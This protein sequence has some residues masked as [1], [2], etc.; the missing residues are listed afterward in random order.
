MDCPQI[1]ETKY[2]PDGN[3]G[4]E[5]LIVC[6]PIDRSRF[7]WIVWTDSPFIEFIDNWALLHRFDETIVI[8][9]FPLINGF[10][11]IESCGNGVVLSWIFVAL[12]LA[13]FTIDIAPVTKAIDESDLAIARTIAFGASIVG[14]LQRKTDVHGSIPSAVEIF[15]QEDPESVEY[16][17]NNFEVAIFLDTISYL[18]K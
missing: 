11:E 1:S 12:Q 5:A 15:C 14:T 6:S 9:K 10:G 8:D 4:S 18:Y 13:E 3:C 7:F 16:C 17:S 2:V